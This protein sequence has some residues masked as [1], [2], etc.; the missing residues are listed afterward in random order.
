MKKVLVL[1]LLAIANVVYAGSYDRILV[2]VNDS[3]ITQYDLDMA[4]EQ[5][6]SRES[7]DELLHALVEKSLQK[8]YAL[9]KGI[10][11]SEAEVTAALSDIKSQNKLSDD[12]FENALASEGLTLEV[13]KKKLGEELLL[14]K[15]YNMEILSKVVVN[16]PELLDYYDKH[17]H[18]FMFPERRKM[19]HIFFADQEYARS[20]GEKVL[21]MLK[22]GEEFESLA[23]QYSDDASGESGG[24]L[25][26]FS[27]GELNEAVDAAAF[28]MGEG[29]LSSLVMSA[30]GYHILRV[31]EI[32]AAVVK[33][34]EVVRDE[35]KKI[36]ESKKS[37]KLYNDWIVK[38]RADAYIEFKTP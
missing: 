17:K 16:R 20:R 1:F 6:F 28:A 26:Y 37:A 23:N 36:V 14:L 11:I 2:V 22:S 30:S 18:E 38:I 25:G 29:E 13:Y 32:Q 4:R 12:M 24:S 7:D 5:G 35:I 19:S 27:R 9:E 33:E 31:D 21:E 15:L 3:V 8:T 34:F 10:R